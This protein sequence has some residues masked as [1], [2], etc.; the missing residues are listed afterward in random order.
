[1]GPIP[2]QAF[3]M[4]IYLMV[5]NILNKIMVKNQPLQPQATAECGAVLMNF[6]NMNSQ[7]KKVFF[8]TEY[9]QTD[10]EQFIIFRIGK[11]ASLH[12]LVFAGL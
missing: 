8:L 9:G 5:K 12:S 1:M 11:T 6:G 7:F 3:H 10:Q 4:V 2:T